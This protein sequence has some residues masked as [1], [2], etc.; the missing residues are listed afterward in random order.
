MRKEQISE[1]QAYTLIILFTMG[2]SLALT[3]YSGDKQNTWISILLALVLATPVV[4]IYGSIMTL[5]PGKDIFEILETIFGKIIGK[6]LGFLYTFYFFHLGALCIRNVTEYI[7]VVSFPE[8][9]QYFTAIFLGILAIYIVK[10]GL[11]VIAR[12]S[13]FLFPFLVIILVTTFLM[14]LQKANFNNLLPILENGWLPVIKASF[15]PFSF[16]FAESVVFL[17]VL[18]TVNEKNKSSKIL[19]IG[20]YGGGFFLLNVVLR[21]ILML[22]FPDLSSSTFASYHAVSLIDIGNFIRGIEIVVSIII[23]IAGFIKISVCLL[24]ASIGICRVFNFSDYKWVSAPIALLMMST[25]FIL[26]EST[27]HMIEWVE[28]YKYY[29]FPFQVILPIIILVVGLIKKKKPS[30]SS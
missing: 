26:F 22:G 30:S 9:P 15:L 20:I 3:S 29:A 19:T 12:V 7:Q 25:S 21:N 23:T 2:T 17:S 24:A 4:L 5:Y 11:E 10:S 1:S 8:T 6:I 14:A 16:P 27:M 18:N 13:K 28:I